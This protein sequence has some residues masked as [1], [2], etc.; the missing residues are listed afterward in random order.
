MTVKN[1]NDRQPMV[2]LAVD[3]S[4]YSVT[5]VNLAVDM[6]ASVQTGLLGLFIEDEDLL[7]VSGLPCTREITL[8][9]TRE[10]PTSTDQMQRSLRSVAQ[11]FK[12]TLQREAQASKIAWHFDTVRGRMRDIG[13]KSERDVT[14]TIF[15]RSV[16]HRLQPSRKIRG[17][18]K[19]LLILD[20]SPRQK[21][22]LDVVLRR[23]HHEKIELTVVG[24]DP[25]QKLSSV[26][27]SQIAGK[28]SELELTR[29]DR[30]DLF[31]LLARAG[32]SFD[33]AIM[34]QHENNADLPRILNAL[35][36]PTILVA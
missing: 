9:T 3:V 13:L 15:G 4:N 23:F 32:S 5:T 35:R 34:S 17:I 33:C 26:L 1:S 7:Q 21:L 11:Q 14:Y 22:A 16:S 10:R 30:D 29:Y 6:A 12:Q 18:R 8:T 19:I 28:D 27:S 31:E 20:D 24:E 2:M 25:K 36:C